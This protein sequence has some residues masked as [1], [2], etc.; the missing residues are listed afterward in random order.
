[1]ASTDTVGNSLYR[2][3]LAHPIL[4]PLALLGIALII[5]VIDIFLLP[6]AEASGEAYLHKVLGLLLILGYLWAAG[7][8]L[9]EIGLHGR[10]VGEALWIGG[11]AIVAVVIL[12]FVAQ[13]LVSSAAGEEPFLVLTAIDSRTGGDWR[14]WSG[15]FLAR[16]QSAKLLDGGRALSRRHADPLSPLP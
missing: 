15:P 14:N 16:Q 13:M 5:R 1:M 3:T 12:A 8:P 9:R 4:I 2:Q 7:R 10:R 11:L 6:L